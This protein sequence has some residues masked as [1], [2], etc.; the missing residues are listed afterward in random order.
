LVATFD[1]VLL[2]LKVFV[3]DPVVFLVVVPVL[4]PVPERE[5]VTVL[6]LVTVPVPVPVPSS[7]SPE[8][9][10]LP[11]LTAKPIATLA[12]PTTKARQDSE[13]MRTSSTNREQTYGCSV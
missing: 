7:P 11:Q 6:A 8:F 12:A 9:E 10:L 1:P 4:V 13:R 5:P 2:R 3:T